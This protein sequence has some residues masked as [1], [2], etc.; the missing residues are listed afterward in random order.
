M[1]NIRKACALQSELENLSHPRFM[2]FRHE[3]K[4]A[5]YVFNPILFEREDAFIKGVGKGPSAILQA[6]HQIEK[7]NIATDSKAYLSG[8][9]TT[10]AY[11]AASE[12]DQIYEVNQAVTKQMAEKKIPITLLGDGSGSIGAYYGMS[13]IYNNVTILN[14]DAHLSLRETMGGTRNHRFTRMHHA[15]ACS[16]NVLHFGVS[17]MGNREKEFF[18]PDKIFFADDIADDKYWLEDVM[19]E[20]KNDVYISIDMSIFDHSFIPSQNPEV[21]GLTYKQIETLLRAIVKKHNVIGIDVSG[22]V[23]N[24][25]NRGPEMVLSKLIYDVISHMEAK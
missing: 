20:I 10:D 23:P 1:E 18:N 3:Y 16:E 5:K 14:L 6:S 7:Y 8:F 9:F 25:E 2:E 11:I 12:E 21:T 13:K 17:S 4:R 24:K 15:K 19:S 22:F